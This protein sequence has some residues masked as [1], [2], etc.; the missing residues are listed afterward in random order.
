MVCMAA[1]ARRQIRARETKAN[2]E[3]IVSAVKHEE[4]VSCAPLFGTRVANVSEDT[5][6]IKRE[7]KSYRA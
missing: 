1:L 6:S 5:K 3:T 7:G 4:G 2:G